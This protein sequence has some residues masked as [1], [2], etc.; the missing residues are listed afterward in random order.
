MTRSRTLLKRAYIAAFFAAFVLAAW[1][2]ALQ[3][4]ETL[5]AAVPIENRTIMIEASSDKNETPSSHTIQQRAKITPLP[6]EIFLKTIDINL[7]D[8]EDF[9]QVILSKKSAASSSLEIIVADFSPAL[10]IYFRYFEGPIAATKLDSIIV[11]SID[12]TADGLADLIVQGLNASNNQ[13]LT[14]FRRLSDRGYARAFSG[15]GGEITIQEPENSET[16]VPASIIVQAPSD[17]PGMTTQSLYTWHGR[18]SSFEKSSETLVKQ[19]NTLNSGPAGTGAQTFLSWLNRLWTRNTDA[20]DTRS[21]FL[22]E[23]NNVLIFGSPQIQQRWVIKSAERNENRL[24]LTCSTSEASDLDR[25][26]VIDAKAQDEIVLGIIDQQVSQFR[27]DEGWSGIYR[28]SVPSTAPSQSAL[29]TEPGF[30]LFFG[31]YLGDDDSVLVLG[32][33]KSVIVMERKYREGIAKLYDYNG[34]RVLDFLQIQSNGLAGE[35]LVFVVS[36]E[37]SGD[38]TIKR[39]RLDPARIGPHGVQLGYRTPYVFTKTS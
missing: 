30:D 16:N 1:L 29:E 25:L 15:F 9:E 39:L 5:Q 12:V 37:Q 34:Y 38:G 10:G 19:N 7:D 33:S 22:D 26:V 21:L 4:Q 31:R 20:S 28:A 11:Q 8:D 36:T 13:T 14:I 27:R 6:E 24:Y 35:R 17:S 32:P 23:K 18:L 3:R 2:V